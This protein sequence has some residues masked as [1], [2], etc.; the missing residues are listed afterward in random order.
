[1]VARLNAHFN[2][3]RGH[4][5]GTAVEFGV[6]DIDAG[7]TDNG[8]IWKVKRGTLKVFGQILLL[9]SF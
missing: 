5:V 3:G 7:F 6:T 9:D 4:F 2:Q 1:M 8:A